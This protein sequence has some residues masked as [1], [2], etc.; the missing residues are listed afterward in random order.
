MS[1]DVYDAQD[2]G[3]VVATYEGEIIAVRHVRIQDGDRLQDNV[4]GG[5]GGGVAGAMVGS[6]M[7]KGSGTLLTEIAGAAIGAT[8]G[9]LTE[10]E[11]KKETG[12]EYIVQ[13]DNGDIKTVVQGAT[14]H[15]QEGEHVWLL[16]SKKGRSRIILK[17]AVGVG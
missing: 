10:R 11:L 8:A 3:E 6:T 9:A 4:I 2:V 13:L 12:I 1:P 5:V 17:T 16:V 7:G 15:L 14:P